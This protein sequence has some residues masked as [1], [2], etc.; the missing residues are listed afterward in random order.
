[1]QQSDANAASESNKLKTGSELY[2]VNQYMFKYAR[3]YWYLDIVKICVS[4][5]VSI[6]TSKR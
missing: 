5:E 3:I 2:N 4:V 6:T 1:M